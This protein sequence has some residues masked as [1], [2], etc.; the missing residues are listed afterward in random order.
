MWWS[1]QGTSAEHFLR[2]ETCVFFC[3]YR[4]YLN[5]S[6][7]ITCLSHSP[8]C[9]SVFCWPILLSPFYY[10]RNHYFLLMP[11][12]W[13]IPY[14]SLTQLNKAALVNLAQQLALNL[15]GTVLELRGRIR[16]HLDQ[17][18]D[19]LDGVQHGHLLPARNPR[20]RAQL[21]Q[22]TP[23]QQGQQMISQPDS[24][25]PE[26]GAMN[27]R[28]GDNNNKNGDEDEFSSWD[29][30]AQ[31][32]SR[33]GTPSTHTPTPVHWCHYC[34]NQETPLFESSQSQSPPRTS[35]SAPMP[36]NRPLHPLSPDS[37]ESITVRD[38]R[39]AM[40]VRASKMQL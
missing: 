17:Y 32:S 21:N 3:L 22:P 20:R 4:L 16:Q 39:V 28:R 29:G 8:Y 26:G 19:A 1:A 35:C 18:P 37:S 6:H 31:T 12:I 2:R 25:R 24:P 36:S 10:Y 5:K 30:I 11:P 13:D 27:Q 7:V 38:K 23:P 9:H 33:T 14:H 40:F 34:C 15:N